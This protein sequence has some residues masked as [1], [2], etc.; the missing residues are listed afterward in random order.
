MKFA[1]AASREPDTDTALAQ[2]FASLPAGPVD[3]TVVF[4]TAQHRG[5]AIHIADR[6]RET[7][8]PGTLIGCTCEGVIGPGEEIERAH[9]MSLLTAS[10][11]G[12]TLDACHVMPAEWSL[13]LSDQTSFRDKFAIGD[14]TRALI[15]IGDPFST[16]PD[17][18][19]EAVD[20]YAP[21]LPA[22]G[23]MAS[24]ASRPWD[25]ALLIDDELH[26]DGLLAL[27]IGG[28]IQ[29]DTVVSQG[30]RPI[31]GRMLVS[32]VEGQMVRKLAGKTPLQAIQEQIETLSEEDEALIEQGLCIGVAVSEYRTEF[33]RGDFLIR[34]LMGVDPDT[35]AIA[36]GEMLRPGQ[37]VQLHVR[38]GNTADE[39]LRFL[40]A[41]GSDQRPPAGAL[42]FSCNGR[43]TRMFETPDHD[44]RV[45]QEVF[46]AMPTAGFFAMGEIGPVGGQNR[47]HGHTASIALFR[48]QE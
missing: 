20:S 5:A 22:I 13:L 18:V 2:L 42:V 1:S 46:P 33:T 38:D 40:L 11:P 37:T 26:T 28:K 32:E 25:N 7:F 14:Q 35:G 23:G 47:L 29:T 36:V 24:G 6:I 45:L 39:D 3:L 48:E 30:C 34:N 17:R 19:L 16:H 43:G 21:G 12:V 4:L 41:A 27:T 31:G 9:G 10:L 8:A 44:I 15:L